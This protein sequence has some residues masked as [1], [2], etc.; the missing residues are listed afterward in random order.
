MATPHVRSLSPPRWPVWPRR[1]Y[2]KILHRCRCYPD[3]VEDLELG[4]L[5]CERSSRA[6]GRCRPGRGPRARAA[7]GRA[8]PRLVSRWIGEVEVLAKLVD[9]GELGRGLVRGPTS[10][11]PRSARSRSWPSWWT[12][13]SSAACWLRPASP[14]RRSARSRSWPS[15]STKDVRAFARGRAHLGDGGHQSATLSGTA[16]NGAICASVSSL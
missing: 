12:P 6:G 7:R 11:R 10:P 9:A 13:A 8:R 3:L 16:S 4:Q 5:E 14:R 1:R 2:R 15:W